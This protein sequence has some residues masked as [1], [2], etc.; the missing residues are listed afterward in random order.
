MTTS[1]TASYIL[2]S[3]SYVKQGAF[4]D[5]SPQWGA[6]FAALGGESCLITPS[7][8]HGLPV[9]EIF[10]AVTGT[11]AALAFVSNS[12]AAL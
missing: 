8:V 11:T 10:M 2:D 6:E 5:N 9:G 7:W 4:N 12:V 3:E 1:E